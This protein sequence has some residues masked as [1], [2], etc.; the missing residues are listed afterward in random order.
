MFDRQELKVELADGV[1]AA[2]QGRNHVVA[3]LAGAS[4][5]FALDAKLAT[6]ELITNALVHGHGEVQLSACFDRERGWLRV[7]V[8]DAS[9]DLPQVLERGP[10]QIG[11]LGLGIVAEL[12]TAWGSFPGEHGKTVWFELVEFPM[13]S[14]GNAHF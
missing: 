3:L 1:A 11:G 14:M 13:D 2:A 4:E 6:S 8:S 10:D 12:S 7:E 9:N 5:S